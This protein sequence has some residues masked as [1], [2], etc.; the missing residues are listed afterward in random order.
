[1]P[2]V[3][4][5]GLVGRVVA[6]NAVAARVQLINDASSSINIRLQQSGAEA[7]LVGQVTGDITLQM[8]PQEAKVEAGDV[9]VTSGL[10]G[11]YPP[12]LLIGQV[13]GVRRRAYDIFQTAT[14]QP[15]VDFTHLNIVLVITNFQPVDISP[16]IPTPGA[17]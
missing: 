7:I 5:D 2:V 6:V 3:T 4:Q 12:N 14:V 13:T 9:I 11:D 10:G 8:I 1:M 15:L 16:L 17:P